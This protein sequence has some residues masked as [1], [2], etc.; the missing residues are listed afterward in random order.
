MPDHSGLPLDGLATA[1]DPILCPTQPY[2]DQDQLNGAQSNAGVASLMYQLEY[3]E[4]VPR[5][6]SD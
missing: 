3:A 6:N 4:A 5:F 1:I 2:Y